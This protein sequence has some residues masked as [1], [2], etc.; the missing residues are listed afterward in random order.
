MSSWLDWMRP[1]PLPVRLVRTP[2]PDCG[3]GAV[4]EHQP[5]WRL[6]L[7]VHVPTRMGQGCTGRTPVWLTNDSLAALAHP[8]TTVRH[9]AEGSA[10]KVCEYIRRSC[11]SGHTHTQNTTP[12]ICAPTVPP[13]PLQSSSVEL[14]F[15]IQPSF[16]S[17]NYR[18]S[19]QHDRSRWP[20]PLSK[21]IVRG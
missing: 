2:L 14:R 9:G 19:E 4:V 17:D 18:P 3:C 15:L 6:G 7:S 1:C 10:L 20:D 16:R 13:V 11:E 5:L 12:N 21:A 8:S